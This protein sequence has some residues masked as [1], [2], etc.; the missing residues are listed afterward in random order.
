MCITDR[1]F[2]NCR[3]HPKT[4]AVA[5]ELLKFLKIDSYAYYPSTGMQLY[6]TTDNDDGWMRNLKI[7]LY[8]HRLSP[9]L[10]L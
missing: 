9:V 3:G 2:Y 6:V 5:T 8:V 10:Q 4:V 1:Q 7:N